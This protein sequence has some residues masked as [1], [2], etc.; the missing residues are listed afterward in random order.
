MNFSELV[1]KVCN[2]V[3]RPDMTFTQD[4]GSGEAVNAVLSSTVTLHTREFYWRD[5]ATLQAKFDYAAYIQSLDLSV[6]PRFRRM[7][8][9]RKWDPSMQA[10]QSDPSVTPPANWPAGLNFLAQVTPDN[11]MDT[12]GYEKTDIWYAAGNSLYIK[13]STLLNYALLGYYALPRLIAGSDNRYS[14]FDSWIATT[15]PWAIIYHAASKLFAQIGQQ[16][17]SRKYDSPAGRNDDGGLVQQQIKIIDANNIT[18][19]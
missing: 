4:G 7:S 17:T 16:D 5:I 11:V 10:F 2:E 18:A 9:V 6:F 19:G 13:S 15:Y 8:Y 3:N 12:Y 1:D 14:V